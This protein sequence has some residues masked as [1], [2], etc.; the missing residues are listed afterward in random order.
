M[1]ILSFILVFL[2]AWWAQNYAAPV[3]GIIVYWWALRILRNTR[4]E[5]QIMVI[6]SRLQGEIKEYV[7]YWAKPLMVESSGVR[8]I[9]LPKARLQDCEFYGDPTPPV[10]VNNIILVD[11][12]LPLP[13][14]QI[15]VVYPQSSDFG[16]FALFG[17]INREMASVMAEIG[18]LRASNED[19]KEA[20]IDMFHEGRFGHPDSYDA[21]RKLASL[22]THTRD[23]ESKLGNTA[24]A[25]RNLFLYYKDAIPRMRE[26]MLM[27][28]QMLP[29]MATAE[30]S[31]FLHDM[32]GHPMSDE[33]HQVLEE[34]SKP[35]TSLDFQKRMVDLRKKAKVDSSDAN[36]TR[37]SPVAVEVNGYGN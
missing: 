32:F 24:A 20:A 21:K 16:N 23:V 12:F 22:L 18:E 19:M 17:R 13:N 9:G 10:T 28:E 30:A 6:E 36:I 37:Q 11:Y 2:G 15:I 33:I 14:G 8:I 31:R 27:M 7:D 25:Q 5:G 35:P 34:M 3:V 29:H 1:V 26:Q 4:K